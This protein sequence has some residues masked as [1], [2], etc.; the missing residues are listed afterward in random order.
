MLVDGAQ[1]VAH[2]RTDVAAL[3]CDFY[4][5]SGHKIFGPTGV[6]VLYGKSEL[7][8][9]MPPFLG[10]GEMIRSV[11]LR[12]DVYKDPPY[13]FEAGTPDIAGAIGLGAAV[14]YLESVGLDRI[15]AHDDELLD[16][17][18][19]RLQEI[20]RLRVDRHGAGQVEYRLLR[21]ATGFT[22]TTWAR[23]S[24]WRASR[25]GPDT[26]APSR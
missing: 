3:D 1:A 11:T 2:E 6:G 8:E 17:A 24:T 16:Y 12:E 26:T 20:P 22:P 4:A 7:L 18:T 10:G 21:A 23:C 15:A 13:R 5:F 9:Q 25:C 19:R 14:D